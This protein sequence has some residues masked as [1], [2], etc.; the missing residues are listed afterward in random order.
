MVDKRA[1]GGRIY[2]K[3]GTVV[4]VAMP[5]VCDVH[6]ADLAK[7]VQVRAG[8]RGGNAWVGFRRSMPATPLLPGKRPP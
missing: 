4:D 5:R 1:G 8:E 7:T 6:L 2:L 3:K